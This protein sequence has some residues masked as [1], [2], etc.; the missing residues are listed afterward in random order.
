MRHYIWL[1]VLACVVAL[2]GCGSDSRPGMSIEDVLNMEF[3][4]DSYEDLQEVEEVCISN[5]ADKECGSDGCGGICGECK[6]PSNLCLAPVCIEGKCYQEPI[7]DSCDDGN[8]CHALVLAGT[9]N[10]KSQ[11]GCAVAQPGVVIWC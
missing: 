1:I 5:C 4:E 10:L 3:E 8:V 7:E 6:Q 9:K 2:S 11:A